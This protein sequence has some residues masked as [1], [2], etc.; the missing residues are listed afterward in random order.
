M[1]PRN[2]SIAGREIL[3]ALLPAIPS[4]SNLLKR[5]PLDITNMNAGWMVN[6]NILIFASRCIYATSQCAGLRPDGKLNA[7]HTARQ[8]LYV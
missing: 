1:T 8:I 2:T 7:S 3:D 5:H 6:N 4:I